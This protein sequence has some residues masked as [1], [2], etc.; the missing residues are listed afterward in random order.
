MTQPGDGKTNIV[1]QRSRVLAWSAVMALVL[2]PSLWE[3]KY[4]PELDLDDRGQY[5]MHAEALAEGRPYTDIGYIYSHYSPKTGPRIAPPGAPLTLAP[6][7]KISPHN[8]TPFKLL[9]L[10][11][12]VAFIGISGQYIARRFDVWLGIV[13]ALI[14]G[15]ALQA[16]VI[17]AFG[18]TDITFA[19]LVWA[20]IALADSS[21]PWS[22]SRTTLITAVGIAAFLYR[23]AAVP[24]IPA[25]F[26]FGIIQ[27]REQRFRPLVPLLVWSAIF[28]LSYQVLKIGRIPPDPN[29]VVPSPVEFGGLPP[30]AGCCKSLI[31]LGREAWAYR[32]GVFNSHLYP[33]PWGSGNDLYHLASAGLMIVG[34][35][36][37]L[38]RA[39][40][41]FLAMFALTYAA[42]LLLSPIGATRYLWPLF[43][44]LAFAFL[45]GLR[46]AIGIAFPRLCASRATALIASLLAVGALAR[47]AASPAP[48]PLVSHPAL[49]EL[50]RVVEDANARSGM[51][52][53]F[54]KP[55]TLSWETGVPAMP[56]IVARPEMIFEELGRQRITH[57]VMGSLGL[58]P[59][60]T[61]FWRRFVA[62]HPNR[63]QLEFRNPGF[64]LYRLVPV[65]ESP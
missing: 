47:Q 6:I 10:M 11:S 2:L 49:Q 12:L 63:F 33:F 54:S 26:L 52:V 31:R 59:W 18:L 32:E 13:T 43:P 55:R 17:P 65:S 5:L 29:G 42:M 39:R 45:W 21:R 24:L 8:Q 30:D 15:I 36:Y 1:P 40:R 62:D 25:V 58:Q 9:V 48:G 44:V 46:W 64:S 3:W 7:L 50:F 61:D 34:L 20:V 27:F 19:A 60:R 4:A 22:M 53:A 16:D 38:P 51:R 23:T 41:Q 57:V 35:I 28:T 14:T 56:L 37:W